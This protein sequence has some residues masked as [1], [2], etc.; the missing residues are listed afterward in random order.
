VTQPNGYVNVGD[1]DGTEHRATRNDEFDDVHTMSSTF[2]D[3]EPTEEE[4]KTLRRI[5]DRL[6][7]SVW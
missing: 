3:A 5:A 1:T 7:W 2:Y 6:P 4:C